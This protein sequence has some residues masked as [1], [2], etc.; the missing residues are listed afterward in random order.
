MDDGSWLF[1]LTLAFLLFC[2]A[3][4]AI[5]ETAFSSVSRIRL[6]TLSDRGDRQARSAMLVVD[7][8]DKAI[9]TLLICVNIVQITT[10]SLVTVFATRKW[11]MGAVALSTV[12]AT[13][14]V[15][16]AGD[17][18]PKTLG[19]KYS[20]R[21]ALSTAASLCFFMKIFS[22]VS[23]ALTA[24]GN[25]AARLFGSGGEVTVTEDE[26]HDIIE[27]MTDGGELDAQQGELVQSALMFAEVPVES[28]LTAR[29]DLSAI[30]VEDSPQEILDYI[31]SQRHS[32]LPVYRDSIDNVIGVLQIRKYI[33]AYLKKGGQISLEELLDE[34]FFVHQS[35][36]IDELLP[37]MSRK[38][39]NMAIVVD[40]YGG[41]LGLVTVEDILEE[42]VG[43]IWDEDDECEETFVRLPDGGFEIDPELSVEETLDL[44][45]YTDPED[46][47]WAHKLM[48]EW[49]Y[50]HFELL[51]R[52][53][54][55]FLYHN[56]MVTV[57]GM[58]QNRI[59][60]LMAAI[61]SP[62]ACREEDES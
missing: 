4:L 17:M 28:V 60:K 38:K 29:V 26:L 61:L 30:D 14:T 49:A 5:A 27:S 44:M 51:P 43:E 1:Y 55:S 31:K 45:D 10:A 22:P 32:R 9:T 3:Y 59:T 6:K 53:G 2:T 18:L 40:N 57:S 56:L 50:E 25:A 12:I 52:Q 23:V 36:K 21:V 35:A 11:G 7:N 42:L 15:F 37:E 39:I 13:I 48:G 20:E 58:K 41:T 8:F 34:A 46:R 19:K 24:L 16:F 33:K 54:D 47:D 62:E